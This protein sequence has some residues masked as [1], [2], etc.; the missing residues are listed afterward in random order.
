M[1]RLAYIAMTG[2]KH[3]LEAQQVTSHNLANA[4]TPGFRA[5]LESLMSRPVQGPGLPARAYSEEVGVG[6]DL[7]GGTVIQTGNELDVAIKGQGWLAVQA[8]D[9]TEGYT[10]RGDLRITGIRATMPKA[11][12]IAREKC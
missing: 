5:D 9:G 11:V 7:S 8:A 3:A 4:N 2:A 12:L 6:S 1:D 10:R